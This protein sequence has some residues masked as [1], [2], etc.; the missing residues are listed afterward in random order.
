MELGFDGND[1][2]RRIFN[3]SLRT[4]QRLEML[5]EAGTL[6]MLHRKI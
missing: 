2:S 5:D 1:G 6:L 4:N 3:G